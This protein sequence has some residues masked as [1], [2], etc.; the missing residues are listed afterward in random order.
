MTEPENLVDKYNLHPMGGY[1]N[2]PRHMANI[3]ALHKRWE[4]LTAKER[5]IANRQ[6]LEM[7][8]E[9]SNQDGR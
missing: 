1:A 6:Y 4:S 2:D 8:P 9:T 5:E 3:K 7:Y